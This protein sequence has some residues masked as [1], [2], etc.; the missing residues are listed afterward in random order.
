MPAFPSAHFSTGFR[1]VIVP[2]Y[3]GKKRIILV[4]LTP[5]I[6]PIWGIDPVRKHWHTAQV[7][8][9][10]M[11]FLVLSVGHRAPAQ[12]TSPACSPRQS[13]QNSA[14]SPCLAK[15]PTLH[16][17]RFTKVSIDLVLYVAA[18]LKTCTL[19]AQ[20]LRGG[21]WVFLFPMWPKGPV[22]NPAQDVTVLP[23]SPHLPSWKQ[24]LFQ[25][26][27]QPGKVT[28]LGLPQSM[29]FQSLNGKSACLPHLMGLCGKD[30]TWQEKGFQHML[31]DTICLV[32]IRICPTV[33][34]SSTTKMLLCNVQNLL[35]YGGKLTAT[36]SEWAL[37]FKGRWV[38]KT[39]EQS[40]CQ[41]KGA[42]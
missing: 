8:W 5:V 35:S 34:L 37:S 17:A 42:S 1:R 21:L 6:E 20:K 26:Q 14:T 41:Q 2:P 12:G 16:N 29:L 13:L 25:M 31:R 18:C 36:G 3:Q 10:S 11:S 9:R 39:S 28:L 7:L 24:R 23:M 30:D 33:S 32:R 27:N 19:H 40:I 38:N 22:C 15:G 4:K